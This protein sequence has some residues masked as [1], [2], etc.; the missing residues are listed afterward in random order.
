MAILKAVDFGS[1]VGAQLTALIDAEIE[2]AER[3]SEYIETVGFEKVK[4]RDGTERLKLRT[5]SFDMRRRDTDGSI[6]TH[7]IRVPILTLIP[8][9]MLA[10]EEATIDFDLYVED[11]REV[12]EDEES[13]G[14][15]RGSRGILRRRRNTLK[16]RVART[17]HS[18]TSTISDL[19]MAVRIVQSDFP[20]GIERLLNTAD[21]SL[22]DDVVEDG[23]NDS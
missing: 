14:S 6:R 11:I 2:G 22:E 9:P 15:T 16:T 23:E 21:L 3:T 1:F 10:I 7:T 19:K 12:K 20:V 17:T 13:E 18:K 5:V 4:L 8:I